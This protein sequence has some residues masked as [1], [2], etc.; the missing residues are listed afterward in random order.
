LKFGGWKLLELGT[1][2]LLKAIF[3]VF[4]YMNWSDNHFNL[5]SN[6]V[7]R[8]WWCSSCL[9]FLSHL[10]E[11]RLSY[12]EEEPT[13]VFCHLWSAKKW[14]GGVSVVLIDGV[15]NSFGHV[16]YNVWGI[17]KVDVYLFYFILFCLETCVDVWTSVGWLL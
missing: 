13:W 6:F 15:S 3:F 1:T 8:E 4:G 5:S 17:H 7:F 16:E 2:L 11:T 14:V 12:L 9:V 10:L